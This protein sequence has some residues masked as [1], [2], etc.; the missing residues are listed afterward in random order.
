[1]LLFDK[2]KYMKYS[3]ILM[4]AQIILFGNIN[5][6]Y[7]K[8][9]LSRGDGRVTIC[10]YSGETNPEIV[11]NDEEEKTLIEMIANKEKKSER[12]ADTDLNKH[13]G[14]G[15]Q[16]T[17]YDPKAFYW[18]LIVF[19]MSNDGEYLY[20]Y[21]IIGKYLRTYMDG[22]KNSILEKMNDRDIETY[23]ID[24]AFKKGATDIAQKEYLLKYLPKI[25]D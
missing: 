5:V 13:Q 4:A 12:L 10:M 21:E 16:H 15:I 9:D 25:K 17:R 22:G 23:L 3:I 20:K 7:A 24:L 8:A 1:M 14:L 18:G 11:L 6:M 19:K 2:G